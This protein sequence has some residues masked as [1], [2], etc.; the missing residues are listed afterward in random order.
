MSQDSDP[1]QPIPPEEAS[2]PPS[3]NQPRTRRKALIAGAA[4]VGVA[5][6]AAIVVVAVQPAP[7]PQRYTSMPAPC[8]LVPAATVARYV[9]GAVSAG[10]GPSTSGTTETGACTWSGLAG[11][12]AT[13]LTVQ[14]SLHRSA[15]AVTDAKTAFNAA[16][17]PGCKCDDDMP[18]GSGLGDE[19]QATVAVQ[20]SSSKTRS[21]TTSYPAT[22]SAVLETRSGNADVR[23]SYDITPYQVGGAVSLREAAAD[24]PVVIAA[25]RAV[26]HSLA[27]PAAVPA[28]PA[29]VTLRYAIPA[30]PCRLVSM[31]TLTRYLSQP[32]VAFNSGSSGKDQSSGAGCSWLGTDGTQLLLVA[33][34]SKSVSGVFAAAQGFPRFAATQDSN[35]KSTSGDTTTNGTQVV[36]GVG[37][38]ALAIFQTFTDTSNSTI[39]PSYLAWLVVWSGNADLEFQ[40]SY[41][42]VPDTALSVPPRRAAQLSALVTVARNVLASLPRS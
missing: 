29:A 13:T 27:H 26:L 3:S 8:A 35:S 17:V 38:Q 5:A 31:A 37:N 11:D 21:V 39:S 6:A 40:F 15:T 34:I 18:P 32:S 25:A 7:Q 14:V 23:V 4:A 36:T 22:A 12:E 2:P 28:A 16:V 42:P 33:V 30:D 10:Q 19:A 1:A 41:T 24:T 20:T 9:T